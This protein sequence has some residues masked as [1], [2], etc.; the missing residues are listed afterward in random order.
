MAEG[1]NMEIKECPS[2]GARWID[3]QLFWSTG[4]PGRDVDL[5]GLVCNTLQ[6]KDPEKAKGCI[7]PS[8]GDETGT[9]WEKRMREM[10]QGLDGL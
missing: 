10:E 2:C 6:T 4:K 3:G 1:K 9:T 8:K 7:N 5:S